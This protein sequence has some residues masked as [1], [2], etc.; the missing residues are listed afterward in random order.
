VAL[1]ALQLALFAAWKVLPCRLAVGHLEASPANARRPWSFLIAPLSHD[2]LLSL[3]GNL[4]V[5]WV[6]SKARLIDSH[7]GSLHGLLG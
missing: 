3:V 5:E 7:H 2:S 4:Q 1:A 6:A